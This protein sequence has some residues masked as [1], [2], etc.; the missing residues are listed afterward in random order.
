VHDVFSL[1]YVRLQQDPRRD[2][3]YDNR[4][5]ITNRHPLGN[6]A[7]R[8][9][10][11]ISYQAAVKHL[12]PSDWS[13]QGAVFFRDTWGLVSARNIHPQNDVALMQY[14]DEDAASAVGAELT[15][16][17]ARGPN[18]FELSYTWQD[19]RGTYSREDGPL[20][21]PQ[22]GPRPT[23]VGDHA[24]DWD[25]RHTVALSG[26]WQ[27]RASVTLSF[28][29]LIGSPLPW[30]PS[31]QGAVDADLSRV[32][33]GRLEWEETTNVAARW[34]LGWRAQRLTLGAEMRNV[35]NRRND[36]VAS[37]DGYPNPDI[38]TLYDDYGAYR[39]ETG[40]RG[41]AY[42]DGGWVPVGDPRLFAPPRTLRLVIETSW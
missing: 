24:L 9:A 38:N 18:R 31:D 35:F 30:T 2:L 1:A 8:P 10:T 15:V 29:S 5:K 34:S 40:N 27:P 25:R 28:S 7:L 6:P 41:G 33:T 12:F 22:I 13:L 21:G 16:I 19:A 32:N 42:Y 4:Q 14:E 17:R 26:I 11:S 39:N 37:V 23:S 36:L 3:L 20:Y